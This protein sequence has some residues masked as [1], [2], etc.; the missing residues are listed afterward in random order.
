MFDYPQAYR[1][2]T[3]TSSLSKWKPNTHLMENVTS[4]EKF[5]S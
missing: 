1:Q 2:N 4:F 5:A 3:F